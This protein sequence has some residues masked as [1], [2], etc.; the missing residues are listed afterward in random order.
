MD[1][2]EIEKRVRARE[3]QLAR[4]H[5]RTLEEMRGRILVMGAFVIVIIVAVLTRR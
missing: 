5:E 3:E 4:E 2:S 1:E